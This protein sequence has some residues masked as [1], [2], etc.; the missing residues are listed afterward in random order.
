MKDFSKTNHIMGNKKGIDT[1]GRVY[2]KFLVDTK[3]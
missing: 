2:Y 3:Q 1:P